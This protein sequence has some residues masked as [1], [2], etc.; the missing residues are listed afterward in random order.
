MLRLEGSTSAAVEGKVCGMRSV[1]CGTR[2]VVLAVCRPARLSMLR[3]VTRWAAAAATCDWTKCGL[4][5]SHA[6]RQSANTRVTHLLALINSSHAYD[7]SNTL[8][9]LS[10]TPL[11]VSGPRL[12]HLFTANFFCAPHP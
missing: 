9:N 2:Y 10:F 3:D 8:D 11:H 7:V 4:Q 12:P 5:S 6:H 1:V